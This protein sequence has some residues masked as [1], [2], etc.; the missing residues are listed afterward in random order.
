MFLNRGPLIGGP[1]EVIN[2]LSSTRKPRVRL[3]EEAEEGAAVTPSV[4][5]FG[6]RGSQA[7]LL[8]PLSCVK[9]KTPDK[10]CANFLTQTR[11]SN[12][13]KAGAALDKKARGQSVHDKSLSLHHKTCVLAG[14]TLG[15]Y[16]HYLSKKGARATQPFNIGGGVARLRLCVC[17]YIYIYIHI[18]IYIYVERERERDII[19]IYIYI[20]IYRLYI[21][22]YIQMYMY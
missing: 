11:R 8:T 18:Y 4:S 3:L 17:I 2:Y 9:D 20:Y 12:K 7:F 15:K 22:I 13:N 21:Y 1:K 14:P 16:Q 10:C 6:L 5:A 19:N